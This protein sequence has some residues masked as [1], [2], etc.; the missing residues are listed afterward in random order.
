MKKGFSLVEILVAVAIFGLI[1]GLVLS[2]FLG[3][4]RVNRATS[5]EGRAVT[6]AK[7]FF[8]RA[9]RNAVYSASGNAYVLTVPAPSQTAGFAVTLE[10]GGRFPKDSSITLS[11]CTQVDSTFTCTVNCTQG[12]QT[13]RCTL[14]TLK[15]TLSGGNKA[16]TFF[17]EWSP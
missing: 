5:A 12:N 15:L 6:V 17:R 9:T 4:F 10:A 11:P 16:Y 2:S 13:V 8:E 14:V 1:S 3:I 7:D